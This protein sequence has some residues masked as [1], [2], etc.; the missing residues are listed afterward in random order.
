M[1]RTSSLIFQTLFAFS[2]GLI[3]IPATAAE[4]RFYHPDPL[5]SNVL[6]T[7]RSGNVI[8]RATNTPYGEL[9]S[10][11][12]GA[13]NSIEPG[14]DSTRHLFTGQ[15]YDAESG[16]SYL[17][18]RHYDP[19]IGRFLAVD[20]AL[21]GS[22]AGASFQG[23]ASNSAHLNGHSYALNL[24]TRLVDPTGAT[25]AESQIAKPVTSFALPAPPPWMPPQVRMVES[26]KVPAGVK[27]ALSN[28]EIRAELWDTFFS[29]IRTTAEGGGWILQNGAVER[30]PAGPTEAHPAGL[31]TRMSN[32]VYPVPPNRA[33][34]FHA[35]PLLTRS[36]RLSHPAL[37]AKDFERRAGGDIR[38]MLDNPDEYNPQL[39]LDPSGIWAVWTEANFGKQFTSAVASNL[40]PPADLLGTAGHPPGHIIRFDEHYSQ[41]IPE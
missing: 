39:I 4:Y 40:G 13:G 19:F 23:I 24:P 3:S 15:E 6:V 10:V 25:P 31:Y 27:Q 16:L 30:W 18:A 28:L 8:Q 32:L 20:P 5:G 37:R 41:F 2:S 12:D 33:L 21:I 7:D 38:H 1:R 26:D 29:T 9:R 35:H 11:N 36:L 14:A 17:G 22:A 34:A